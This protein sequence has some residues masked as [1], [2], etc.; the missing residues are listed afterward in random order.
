M[1][2]IFSQNFSDLF[3]GEYSYDNWFDAPNDNELMHV[4]GADEKV[5]VIP[6][7][8]GEEKLEKKVINISTSNHLLPDFHYY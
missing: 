2:F 4:L 8:E 7:L 3:L 6:S 5:S 1:D